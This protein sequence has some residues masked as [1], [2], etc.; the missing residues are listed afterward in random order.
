MVLLASGL[1]GDTENTLWTI[2]SS[3]TI[4]RL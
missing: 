1:L 2:R 3:L 4:C